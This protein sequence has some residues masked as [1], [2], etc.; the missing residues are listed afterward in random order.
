[1][2][3][4]TLSA[5]MLGCALGTFIGVFARVLAGGWPPPEMTLVLQ[6]W[7]YSGCLCVT[8]PIVGHFCEIVSFCGHEEK[9][10]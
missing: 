2:M 10:A 5:V 7:L 8:W 6:I 1:M 9:I 4:E 3:G